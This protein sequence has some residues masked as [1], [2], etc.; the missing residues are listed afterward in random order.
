MRAVEL[1]ERGHEKVVARRN[2]N[3]LVAAHSRKN[4]EREVKKGNGISESQHA[5]S[6]CGR[7]RHNLC[8]G[9]EQTDDLLC[10]LT[11][12]TSVFFLHLVV[13]CLAFVAH[14]ENDFFRNLTE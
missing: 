1:T 3:D 13:S 7:P 9:S 11:L 14:A 6:I 2:A 10:W 8:E 12:V 4:K 5:N